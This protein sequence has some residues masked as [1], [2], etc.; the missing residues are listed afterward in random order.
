MNPVENLESGKTRIDNKAQFL[1]DKRQNL[2]EYG[3]LHP[4][5]ARKNKH[6]PGKVYN[7][8]K[9]KFIKLAI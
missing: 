2:Y 7:Y 8:M 6:I 1:I 4:M 3:G 5:I 9:E